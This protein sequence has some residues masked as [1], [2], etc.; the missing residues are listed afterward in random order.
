MK[1]L[2]DVPKIKNRFVR[3]SI[4]FIS[5]TVLVLP[6]FLFSVLVVTPS[7]ELR[8][9]FNNMSMWRLIRK[10]IDTLKYV[11]SSIVKGS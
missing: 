7:V 11:I 1:V 6:L 8:R 2:I 4:G 10:D 9:A 3:W 5:L